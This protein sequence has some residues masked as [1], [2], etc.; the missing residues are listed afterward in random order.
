MRFA[1]SRLEFDLCW[2]HLKLGEYP[3]ILTIS[4]HGATSD[5]RRALL[6]GAWRGLAARGL[7]ERSDLDPRLAGWL[8]LLARPE[9]EVD[10]RLRL[11]DG[12]RIR[13]VAAARRGHAVLAMLTTET[14]VLQRID[15][16]GLADAVVSLLPTHQ[17]PRSRSI[18]LLA[19]DLEKAASVAGA[20]ASKMELALRDNGVPR[21]D[22][23]KIASVLG[24]VT[25]MGQFGTAVR[26]LRNGSPGPRVR[27]PYAVSFYDTEEGRWQFTRR[28]SGD[29]RDW[30]T[31]SPADHQRLVHS[32]S[33]LLSATG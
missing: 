2:E 10:A 20:S 17:T 6:A 16:S 19:T 30:S 7:V 18:S 14:L 25:R 26:P 11:D 23:Q 27:G 33:E 13:A 32:V 3:T 31:L 24:G 4:S 28:P 5:E 9:R 8:E 29:G 22:A 1:L 15:E 12:P 21:P